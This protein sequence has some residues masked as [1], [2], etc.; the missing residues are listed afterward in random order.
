MSSLSSIRNANATFKPKYAPVAVFV[1]GTSGIG[2]A[3]AEVLGRHTEGKV[4]IVIVG[5]NKEAAD[6]LFSKM[7]SPTDKTYK[8]E[9]IRCD[10]TRM[11]NVEAATK[12]ILARHSKINFLIL[13]PGVFTT[14][15]RNETEEGL[16][17]K[18]AVHYYSRWKFIKDLLPVLNKASEEGEDAK[19]FSVLAPG[20]GSEIDLN[21]LGLK[22]TF[23][24]TKAALQAPTYNDLMMEAFHDLN[25]AVTFIH[26]YPGVVR[27]SLFEKSDS[28]LVK[29]ASPLVNLL[30]WP[31]FTSPEDCGE[32]MW[33]AVFNSTDGVFRTGSKGEDLGKQRYFGSEEA[34][35]KL[36]DHT[37]EATAVDS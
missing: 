8:R 13:S 5:R 10:V 9:F 1:G 23:S 20:K 35:K 7:P 32:Y 36:W 2:R 18:L 19:V 27:T 16:D 26:G 3:M 4:D 30:L 21:D 33:H 31:V 22:K 28:T 24:V 37:V 34:K 12:E 11:K 14:R 17:T 15:G 6:E 29:F 25:P